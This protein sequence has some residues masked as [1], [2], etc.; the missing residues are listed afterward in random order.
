VAAVEWVPLP[1][2]QFEHAKWL[3]GAKVANLL[4]GGPEYFATNV[5]NHAEA[6]QNTLVLSFRAVDCMPELY[7]A[8][9]ASDPSVH[10]HIVPNTLISET[11]K[12]DPERL[13]NFKVPAIRALMTRFPKRH[14]IRVGDSGERDPETYAQ[15]L[16][17]FA[18]HVDAI[19]IHNVRD[20]DQTDRY[21]KLFPTQSMAAKLRVFVN[22][23]ELPHSL[24][25]IG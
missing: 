16:A 9:K 19:L 1:N 13:F 21:K 5:N 2:G 4:G 3:D 11:V 25:A 17:E 18:D 7:S 14:L 20:E 23:N 22:P 24:A 8:W 12:A 10:V 15:I 6:R